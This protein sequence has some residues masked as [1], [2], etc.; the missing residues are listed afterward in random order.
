MPDAHPPFGNSI[1]VD[2]VDAADS[3]GSFLDIEDCVPDVIQDIVLIPEVCEVL[4]A[5]A[6]IIEAIVG[7]QFVVE[8]LV[9]HIAVGIVGCPDALVADDGIERG[10]DDLLGPVLDLLGGSGFAPEAEL[11]DRHALDLVDEGVL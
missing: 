11:V 9:P 3:L 8:G 10:R 2:I 5:L 7:A 1:A 4:D 6:A